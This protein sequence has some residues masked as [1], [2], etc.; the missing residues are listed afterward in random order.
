[1]SSAASRIAGA[2]YTRI[3]SEPRPGWCECN[4]LKNL[5]TIVGVIAVAIF[6]LL[7]IM[8][9]PILTLPLAVIAGK[10]IYDFVMALSCMRD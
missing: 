10:M 4:T 9:W 6:G 8:E 2:P 7:L 1:M 3:D 5:A